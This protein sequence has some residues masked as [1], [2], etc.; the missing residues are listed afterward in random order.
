MRFP[1]RAADG[2]LV[3][4]AFIVPAWAAAMPLEEAVR[5]AT[6]RDPEVA[7]MQQ[8]IA[9]QETQIEI[10]KDGQRPRFSVN[11]GTGRMVG[12]KPAYS[13]QRNVDLEL[14][15]SQML[16]DW[17]KVSAQIEGASHDRI[18]IVSNLKK[19]VETL[20]FDIAS[21]YLDAETAKAK[22]EATAEYRQNAARLAEMT[23]AREAGG[24]GD[25]SE[26]ARARLETSRGEERQ[27]AFESAHDVALARLQLLV[28][29]SDISTE[30][31]PELAYR[32]RVD[33]PASLDESIKRAPDYLKAQA[34]MA[35]AQA[36]ID[37]ARATNKPVLRLEAA[38][39]N[40]GMSG[41]GRGGGTLRLVMGVD[42]GVSDLLGR[43]ALAA[44]QKHEASRERLAGVA[45]DLQKETQSYAR[46]IKALA[47]SEAAFKLQADEARAVVATYEEQFT[48]G[49]RS[50]TDL[51]TSIRE[52][53]S[54]QLTW[55]DTADQRRRLQYKAAALLGL[56]GTLLQETAGDRRKV[57]P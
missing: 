8:D 4:I 17:G 27:F 9:Q 1:A 31:V 3:L 49:L 6:L 44:Q 18:Q 41:D 57:G 48:A 24:R 50:M 13:G 53:Y 7:A 23:Q 26:T 11:M 32:Q 45:R 37:V 25:V 33:T 10:I 51:F 19:Q 2:L 55:I 38:A 56:Q 16:F 29:I 40:A 28:G 12:T 35:S 14:V 36:G 34:A 54:T 46:Q 43:Q 21:L 22:L 5:L 39:A 30:A 47:A 20:A 42:L 52:Q 15:A